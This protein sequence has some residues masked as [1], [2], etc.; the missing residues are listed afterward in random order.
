MTTF[1][2][3]RRSDG[4]VGI[5]NHV[6]VMPGVLCADVAV[7]KIH[8][9]QPDSVYMYNPHGCGQ[10][11]R[12]CAVT[13]DILTGLLANGNVY[14]ALIVGLGCEMMQEEMYMKGIAAKTNKPIRYIA[15]QREG[16]IAATVAKGTEIVRELLEEAAKC[17][18]EEIDISELRLGLECG[19]SDPTSGISSNTVLGLVTDRLIENGGTAYMSETAEA[20]GAEHVMRRRGRTPEIGDQLFNTIIQWEKD[21]KDE[22]GID[23]RESNPS[24]GNRASGLTTLAEKSLGCIHKSGSH[25]FDGCVKYGELIREKG[26]FFIDATAYDVAN[27]VALIAAGAQIVAFTTGMGNPVGNPVAPVLKITG[28]GDTARRMYDFIDFDTSATLS[29]GSFEE[30]AD[31]MFNTILDICGGAPVKAELNGACE[32]SINQNYS[33]V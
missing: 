16:S 28:N 7:R 26:L 1:M 19:G 15:I 2:G 3:Y 27:T 5:R 23:I 8:A 9:A 32:M 33:Y 10:N 4:C 29:G 12:D 24:P 11:P 14:G 22:T 20:I 18:R 25:P 6:V 21:R 17:E 30:L 13:L 31:K